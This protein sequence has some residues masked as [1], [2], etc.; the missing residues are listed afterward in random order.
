MHY[1][2]NTMPD[3]SFAKGDG[4]GGLVRKVVT[5]QTPWLGFPLPQ[6]IA[7]KTNKLHVVS[8]MPLQ[9]QGK[10]NCEPYIH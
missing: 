7:G 8:A 9:H 4:R 5:R 3:L 6:F 1:R 10:A 2:L